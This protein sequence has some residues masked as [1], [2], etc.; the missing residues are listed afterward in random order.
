ML[1]VGVACALSLA[2]PVLVYAASRPPQGS[3]CSTS[4]V[5]DGASAISAD[6]GVDVAASDA[7]AAETDGRIFVVPRFEAAEEDVPLPL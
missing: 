2:C 6:A 1:R 4:V 3:G 7:D 5:L